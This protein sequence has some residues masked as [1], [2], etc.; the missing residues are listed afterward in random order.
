MQWYANTDGKLYAGAGNVML[1]A[2]GLTL[3]IGDYQAS[4]LFPYVDIAW[5]AGSAESGRIG[6]GELNNVDVYGM[7]FW[8]GG[9]GI[10]QSGNG[11]F[12]FIS[13]NGSGTTTGTA[14]IVDGAFSGEGQV[15]GASLY[16]AGTLEAVGAAT[17][18]NEINVRQHTTSNLWSI[19]AANGTTLSLANTFVYQF[20]STSV[21][22]GMVLISN[23]TGGATGLFVMGGGQVVKVADGSGAFSTTKDTAS[24]LNLYYDGASTEYRL[25]NN[26]GST[27]TLS[28]F[29]VRARG[30][31]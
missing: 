18:G 24:K 11:K 30:A 22:T 3:D 10:T 19:D 17:F 15:S 7:R 29:S 12:E 28:I 23:A 31:S 8:A 21:F 27:A 1:D 14:I 6:S 5:K 26:S 25:Q 13:R 20:S 9:A 4:K 16:T 2:A